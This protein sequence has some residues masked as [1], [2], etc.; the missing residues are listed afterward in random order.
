M[1]SSSTK[2]YKFHH[3]L[4]NDEENQLYIYIYIYIYIYSSVIC[5][6][7]AHQ[8]AHNFLPCFSHIGIKI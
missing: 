5:T 4:A 7:A 3:S 6:M 8:F 1:P 2:V